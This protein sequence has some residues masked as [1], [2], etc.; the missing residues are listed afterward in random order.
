VTRFEQVD[1]YRDRRWALVVL[2]VVLAL[3]GL[4][5]GTITGGPADFDRP[6]IVA[7]T[8]TPTPTP[9]DTP[10]PTTDGDG[11]GDGTATPTVDGSASGDGTPT[12][13]T[14]PGSDASP[15]P[16]AAPSG[17]GSTPTPTATPTTTE[18]GGGSGSGGAGSSTSGDGASSNPG[19]G[20]SDGDDEGD[21]VDLE[22]N[23]SEARLQFGDVLPG[24][25]GRQTV[26]IRNVG[27][28]TA[29][30]GVGDIKVTDH[31]HG[32]TEPESA[33]DTPGNGGEL[34]AHVRVAIQ[35]RHPDGETEFLYGTGSGAKSLRALAD[36]GADGAS[37]ELA[38]G[39]NATVAFEWH[40][41]VETGNVVQ[42][43]GTTFAVDFGLAGS[44]SDE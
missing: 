31:E 24:D 4:G 14:P 32:I 15:T 22:T 26:R 29:R 44:A 3:L 12:T 19:D 39:D 17:E 35:V 5:I 38:P 40:L 41:P 11:D 37:R 20:G 2:L 16:T 42:S 8:S 30:F 7:S 27:N 33:V 13:E 18:T 23:G 6:G 36:A 21:G 25:S 28:E 43:D 34:S 9:M 10:T 1:Q